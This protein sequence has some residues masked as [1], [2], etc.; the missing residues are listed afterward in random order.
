VTEDDSAPTCVGSCSAVVCLGH[1]FRG[2]R[3]VLIETG[4]RLHLAWPV[5]PSAMRGR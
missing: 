4:R 3:P 5:P 1:Y 2:R